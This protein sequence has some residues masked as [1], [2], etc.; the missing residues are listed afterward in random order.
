MVKVPSG[1]SKRVSHVAISSLA[2]AMRS[3]ICSGLSVLRPRRRCSSASVLGGAT[4]TKMAFSLLFRTC[5]CIFLELYK[6]RGTG[7]RRMLM[8]SIS[9]SC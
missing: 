2:A 6:T 7:M 8:L 4:K 1:G 5:N 9:Y 3:S